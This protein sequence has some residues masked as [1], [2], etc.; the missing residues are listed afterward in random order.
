[1]AGVTAL[2]E[3]IALKLRRSYAITVDPE[4]E[5][6]VTCGATEGLYSA[7]QALVG[8][9]DEVIVFDPAYDSYDPA[10][11]LAGARCVHIPLQPPGFHYDWARVA[12]ALNAR[13][14]LIV[15]NSPHNPSCTR[16]SGADLT[17]LARLVRGTAINVLS[18]EVYEH[19]VFDGG[20]HH[21]VL[22]SPELRE[23]SVAVFSFGKTLHS[24]GLRVGYAV[25]P[26]TLTS[27]LRKVHQFNTFSIAHPLQQAVAGYLREQPD[28]GTR[29]APFFQARRDRLLQALGG[30]GLSLPPAAGT[31]FQLIDYRN[32]SAQGD[33]L[34]AEELLTQA[35][36]ACIPLSVFYQEP[37]PMTLL[38]LCIAKRESTLDDGAHR[39]RAWAQ[40]RGW[41]RSGS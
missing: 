36:V 18:D 13:T 32:W 9:G 1:M 17:E 7:I 30:S 33:L 15:I 4:S 40:S 37:P 39:L 21:S 2:R 16:I 19:V 12:A 24:T 34:M 20:T 22:A 27:E 28:C 25:A 26:A 14:R 11:R 6:T 3:Q 38:R 5:I 41:V 31:F 29:L 35:G 23:R 10:V 8:A